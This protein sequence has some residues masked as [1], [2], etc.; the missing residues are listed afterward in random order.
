[1][2]DRAHGL[3]YTRLEH[4][5]DLPAR[6]F[7]VW[8]RGIPTAGRIRSNPHTRSDLIRDALASGVFGGSVVALF[9]LVVDLMDGRPFFTP[10]LIG[11]VMF[12]GVSAEDVA[13]V[14]LGAVAYNSNDEPRPS[15]S[16][17]HWSS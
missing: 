12:Y 4:P 13:N 15:V 9:F 5:P 2:L 17:Y 16:R 3:G 10:S 6:A 8:P 11:S 14:R 7:R 1:M